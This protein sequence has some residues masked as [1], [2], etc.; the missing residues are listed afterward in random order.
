MVVFLAALLALSVVGLLVWGFGFESDPPVWPAAGLYVGAVALA[1]RLAARHRPRYL[2]GN[3]LARVLRVPAE[4]EAIE[5]PFAAIRDIVLTSEE[6]KDSDGDVWHTYH[7]DLI[8][9]D[10]PPV[11]LTT[12]RGDSADPDALV[13]WLRE[14]VG[15][16]PAIETPS[17]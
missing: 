10:G 8:R 15:L 2:E 11:R 12:Y 1:A 14:R 7:C 17:A 6:H 9:S 4:S 13:A 5:V 3:E 16:A